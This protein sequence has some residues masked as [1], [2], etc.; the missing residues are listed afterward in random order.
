MSEVETKG[1]KV[2]AI[3]ATKAE[4]ECGLGLGMKRELDA[5]LSMSDY[6]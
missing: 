5:K 1:A 4:V 3:E 2:N 6:A